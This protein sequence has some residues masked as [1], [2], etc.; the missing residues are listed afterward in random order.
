MSNSLATRAAAGGRA[1]QKVMSWLGLHAIAVALA[2]AFIGPIVF[3]LLTSLMSDQQALTKNL[4]PT[5]WHWENFGAVFDQAPLLQ[6]FFNSVLY[7]G[8]ATILMLISSIPVA[9]ALSRLKWRG[10]NMM[11]YLVIVAMM[12]PPQV[13][14]VPM[15]VL[16][17]KAG[18]TGTLWPL[19]LPNLVG[20]AFSIFLLRQFLITIPQSYSDS[21]RLDGASE[22]KTLFL[23]I[24]PMAKPGIAAAALFSFLNAWN[25]Y[26]GPLL[27][28]GE[29]PSNWTLSLGLASFRGVHQVQ[30]N[31]T[32][33]ATVL[34][35]AP[36][37]LLFFFAQKQ[38]IEGIKFSGVKG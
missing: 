29:N 22:F 23:V 17:A 16:W 19:I 32:M 25:D 11:F 7:A 6:Y 24:L 5:S 27:Y 21:A 31:L 35:M 20:D 10:R 12:L 2:I 34:V 38:F 3:I 36:I 15:Y 37:I 30:W 4:W 28:A 13:V 1:R 9:Y 33:A 26:F 8:L 14:A 18:L